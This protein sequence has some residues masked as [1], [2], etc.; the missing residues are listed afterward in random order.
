[1]FQ[2]KTITVVKEI[3]FQ[4]KRNNTTQL[5]LCDPAS[6]MEGTE[7]SFARELLLAFALAKGYSSLPG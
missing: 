5:F 4:R 6:E 1:M 3:L 7:G 2:M